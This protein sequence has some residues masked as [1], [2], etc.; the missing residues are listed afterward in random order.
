MARL[1][2]AISIEESV[3]RAK[4][5]CQHLLQWDLF[6]QARTVLLYY[7]LPD[8]LP[9]PPLLEQ[10]YPGKRI[11]LPVVKGEN[12]EL[13][14]YCGPEAILSGAFQIPEPVGDPFINY[15]EIDLCLIPGVAFDARGVRLGRGKGYYDRLLP[16]I[17]SPKAGL[18]YACQLIKRIPA[19]AHDIRMDYLV[20]EEG[21]NTFL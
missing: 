19:E 3:R 17:Q 12:L 5:A 16:R 15:E 9:T 1:R 18:C 7:S 6:E 10:I 2:R 21:I 8:E 14:L 11:L 4:L 13:R 20:T